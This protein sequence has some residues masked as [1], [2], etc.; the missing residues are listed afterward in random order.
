MAHLGKAL[1]CA[2]HEVCKQQ[3]ISSSSK[4]RSLSL[5]TG[6]QKIYRGHPLYRTLD[7]IVRHLPHDVE[8]ESH[9]APIS[10]SDPEHSEDSVCLTELSPKEVSQCVKSIWCQAQ[11]VPRNC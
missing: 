1:R 6:K 3:D 10:F 5:V 7:C 8:G 2:G 9:A 11:K 4:G